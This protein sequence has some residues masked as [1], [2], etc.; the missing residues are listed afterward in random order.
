VVVRRNATVALIDALASRVEDFDP[1]EAGVHG[2][3]KPK[4]QLGRAWTTAVPGA[5]SARS[6][7]WACGPAAYVVSVNNSQAATGA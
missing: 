3:S 5:G 2:L 4:A 7:C 6:S 1:A